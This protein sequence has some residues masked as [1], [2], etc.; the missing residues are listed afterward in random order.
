VSAINGS[1]IDDLKRYLINSARPRS[2]DFPEVLFTDEDPRLTVKK[3]VKVSIH[4]YIHLY[5]LM[6]RCLS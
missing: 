4:L 1:G 6:V 2:W 5:C 3:I